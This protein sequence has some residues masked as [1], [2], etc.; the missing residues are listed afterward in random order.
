MKSTQ[1]GCMKV[2][3]TKLAEEKFAANHRLKM[4]YI[5]TINK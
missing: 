4:T 3:S 2:T 1:N 5:F